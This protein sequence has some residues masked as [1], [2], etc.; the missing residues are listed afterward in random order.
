MPGMSGTQARGGDGASVGTPP[1]DV[2]LVLEGVASGKLDAAR[3]LLPLVYEQLRAAA[4]Q[5]MGRERAGHTLSATALV[6]EAYAR[7][8]GERTV[9]WANRGHFY[10]AAAQAMRRVLIDHARARQAQRRGGGAMREPLDLQAIG[11]AAAAAES[12]DLIELDEAIARLEVQHSDIARMVRLR[13]YAGLSVEQTAMVLEVS[14]RTV[15]RDWAFARAWLV[16]ALR[17]PDEGAGH[18]RR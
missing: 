14:E 17:G 1:T 16:D 18:D 15:K 10:A 4:Q 5:Q 7:L 11:D 3:D 6:H 13:F 8:V 12:G 9:P 2:T